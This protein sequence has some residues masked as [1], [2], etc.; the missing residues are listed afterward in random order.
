MIIKKALRVACALGLAVSTALVATGVRGVSAASV[1]SI[2]LYNNWNTGGVYNGPV[3]TT[4]FT[5]NAPTHI[6]YLEDYHWNNGW[7]AAPGTIGLWG[8]HGAVGPFWAQGYSNNTAWV[9]YVNRTLPPGTYTV[10]DSSISTW[11]YNYI[12]LSQGRG[13]TLVN[14]YYLS[15]LCSSGPATLLYTNWNGF[16]VFTG[17]TYPAFTLQSD[18]C[19]SQIWTY[20]Y[21]NG[22]GATPGSVWVEGGGGTYGPFPETGAAG[23]RV[24]VAN[25][26]LGL[27][28]GYYV[29]VDT[30]PAFESYNAQS[31]NVGFVELIGVS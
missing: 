11:S 18:A 22:A 21:N 24:W 3:I 25:V 31:G 20:H 15:T 8:P 9:A 30:N 16:P 26:T 19:V 14:G 23:N 13:F 27:P 1:A 4:T 12:G 10:V 17:P 28:A 2:N 5:F 6:N 29:L 7:G